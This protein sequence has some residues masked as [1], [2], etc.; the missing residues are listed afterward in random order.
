MA[1]T[2]ATAAIEP[3]HWFAVAAWPLAGFIVHLAQGLL[4]QRHRQRARGQTPSV[5]RQPSRD[6]TTLVQR[7]SRVLPQKRLDDLNA[8][9]AAR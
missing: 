6:T 5:H 1:A 2:C 3:A 7:R 4:H 9:A 8:S